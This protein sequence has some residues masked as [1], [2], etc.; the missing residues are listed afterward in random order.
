MTNAPGPIRI[1]DPAA[2]CAGNG[3]AG[4]VILSGNQGVTFGANTVSHATTID[5]NG[6]GQT[7][8]KA[9]TFFATLSCSGNNPPP[10]NLGQANTAPSKAGQCASL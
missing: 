1:G 6:P 10:T 2:G 5:A 3:F 8:I 9:N 4:Q 7:V